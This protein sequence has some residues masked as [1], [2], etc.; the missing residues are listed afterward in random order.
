M[1][2]RRF[3]LI[4]SIPLGA[5]VLLFI[6]WQQGL[7]RGTCWECDGTGRVLGPY[8]P[9]SFRDTWEDC[10]HCSFRG[11]WR[12]WSRSAEKSLPSAL[13]VAF[14]SLST[15]YLGALALGLR[16]VPCE[17]CGGRGKSCS[18]C[19]DRGYVARLDRWLAVQENDP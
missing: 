18:P 15:L 9:G 16:S 5:V 6:A 12:R 11:R 7:I 14:L 2:E 13:W 1:S 10:D 17:H 4:L 3:L 19:G 8:V